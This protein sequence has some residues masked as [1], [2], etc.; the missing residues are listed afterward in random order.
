MTVQATSRNQRLNLRI[1]AKSKSLLQNAAQASGVSLSD[2]VL[3]TATERAQ[4]VIQAHQIVELSQQAT[5]RFIAA[6]EQPASEAL[7]RLA[8]AKK[9]AH[10]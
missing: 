6:L 4:Q 2:F 5:Q 7:K 9:V 10:L 8:K 1:D 3:Q